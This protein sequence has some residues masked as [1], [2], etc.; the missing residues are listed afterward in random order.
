M[1]LRNLPEDYNSF[2]CAM[3]LRDQLPSTEM[4]RIKG[5]EEFDHRK[6]QN[7]QSVKNVML[8]NKAYRK[9]G[10]N[11]SNARFRSDDTEKDSKMKSYK[12]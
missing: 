6:E 9:I 7:Q 3:T 5:I 4:I 2:R 1:L 10:L 11:W 8:V 12:C